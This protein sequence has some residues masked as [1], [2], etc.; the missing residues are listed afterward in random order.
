MD[1]E[2]LPLPPTPPR[3]GRPH[4]YVIN[5]DEEFLETIGDLLADSR[6]QVT[7]EQLRPNVEV[8]VGNLHSG[9]P[10]LLIL[11]VVPNRRDAA[12]L[13]ERLQADPGLSTLPVLAASTNPAL[14]ERMA[15]LYPELVR[16]VLAKPFD[17]D[18]FFATLRRLQ[19]PVYVP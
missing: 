17:V 9:N 7:L 2:T 1:D 3:D 12:I 11:D 18:D 15:R 8:T 14:A 13:L 19:V 16:E 10:D 6:V 4:I 5:S